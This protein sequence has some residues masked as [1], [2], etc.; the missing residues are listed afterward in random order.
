M[1]IIKDEQRYYT[2]VRLMRIKCRRVVEYTESMEASG[3]TTGYSK[4]INKAIEDI[5]RLKEVLN[6]EF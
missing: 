6:H 4:L 2:L 5:Q 1:S 3:N